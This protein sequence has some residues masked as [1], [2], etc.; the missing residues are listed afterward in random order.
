V[1]RGTPLLPPARYKSSCCVK[2]SY[3]YAVGGLS[4]GLLGTRP[5]IAHGSR[6]CSRW[7][8]ARWSLTR[9]DG[10]LLMSA[11][12]IVIQAD[13]KALNPVTVT[14][15]MTAWKALGRVGLLL[16][17]I[18]SVD[19]LLR[20][21]PT[22][23]RSPEWEFGTVAMTFASLPVVTVGLVAGLASAM[24]R[25]ERGSA[26]VL[27]AIF[28]VMSVFLVAC[29][30]LF[31]SDVPVALAALKNNMPIEAARE[32]KRTITRSVVMGVGFS[33]I[34]VYGSVVSIRYLLRR[35]KDA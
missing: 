24:A 1:A 5:A 16:A 17:A 29:L 11:P 27:A 12:H 25:G 22:A 10:E 2:I 20:W 9:E 34:Y 15:P 32:V 30:L 7:G 4:I 31:A 33:V 21:F 26:T 6:V 8:G 13:R 18:A 3:T 28:C 35:I 19:I 23:F 14:A